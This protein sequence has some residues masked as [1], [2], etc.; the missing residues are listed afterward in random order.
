VQPLSGA[1]IGLAAGAVSALAI[2][3]KYRFG[4]DDSLDVV[5]VHGMG[6]LTGMLLTGLLAT[7]SVNGLGAT[8]LF[9]GGGLTQLGRQ[10]LAVLVTIAWSFG[11]TYVIARVIERTLGLRAC[12]E[13]ELTG[14]DEAEHAETAYDHGSL[15]AGHGTGF[16]GHGDRKLLGEG[17]GHAGNGARQGDPDQQRKADHQA[18]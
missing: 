18:A 16:G 12:A 7:T 9:F 5:A 10:A 8:G 2:R 15:F 4:F 17:A 13:D 6:G 14:I 1:L 3:L 11:L